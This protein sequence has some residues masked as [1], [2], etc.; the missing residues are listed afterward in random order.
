MYFSLHGENTSHTSRE[1]NILKSKDKE[2]PKF[3]KRDFKKK[4]REINLL[5][6]KASQQKAKYL[7]YKSLNKASPKKKTPVILEDSESDS[8]SS[9]EENSSDEGEENSMTYDS[10]SGGS[11]KISDNATNTEE[12]VWKNVCRDLIIIDKLTNSTSNIK[13]HKLSSNNL[14]TALH[15]AHLLN[16]LRKPSFM[17]KQ[18]KSRK[19]LKHKHFSPIIF[20]KLVIPAGKKDRQSKTRLFKALVYSG[21]SESILTKAKADKLTVKQ[22]K[23]E[24]HWFTAAGVLTTNT[25]IATSFSF[26]ELHSNKLINQ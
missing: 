23:K 14:D 17:V 8:S 9:E 4:S 10:E 6:K 22:T 11:D 5:E 15:D 24:R 13:E 25:K 7:K 3:S 26:P 20:V 2:K 19:K 12:E 21:D 1:C 18:T 16:T